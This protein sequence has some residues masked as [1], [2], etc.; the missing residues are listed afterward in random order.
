MNQVN[1]N[2]KIDKIKEFREKSINFRHWYQ[3]PAKK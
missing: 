1:A 3:K 2:E